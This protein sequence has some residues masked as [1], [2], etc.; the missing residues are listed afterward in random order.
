MRLKEYLPHHNDV[1]KHVTHVPNV[2]MSTLHVRRRA[3]TLSASGDGGLK[4]SFKTMKRN[5]QCF[6]PKGLARARKY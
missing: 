4:G 3:P 5:R 1:A 6:R 2:A